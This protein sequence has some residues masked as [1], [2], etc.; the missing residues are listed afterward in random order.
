MTFHRQHIYWSENVCEETL[1][2][3]GIQTRA[4]GLVRTFLKLLETLWLRP[5]TLMFIFIYPKLCVSTGVCNLFLG[6]INVCA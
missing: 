6:F 5:H 1:A 3:D 4:C 2:T